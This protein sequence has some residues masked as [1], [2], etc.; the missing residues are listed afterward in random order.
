V[1]VGR[2]SAAQSAHIG[3]PSEQVLV[4]DCCHWSHLAEIKWH[5]TCNAP[6]LSGGALRHCESRLK[7]SFASLKPIGNSKQLTSEWKGADPQI[8]VWAQHDVSQT[9]YLWWKTMISSSC[10]DHVRTS[11]TQGPEDQISMNI[12]ALEEEPGA[13]L[14]S[15]AADRGLL[16]PVVEIFPVESVKRLGTGWG[17]W[18]S[19]SVH[20]STGS[21]I[22]FRFQAPMHLLVMYHEGGR[23]D[24]ETIIDGAAP[25]RA[26]SF[27]NKLTFVPAGRPYREWHETVASTRL[28]FLYL[29]PAKFEKATE[30]DYAPRIYF[31]DSVVWETAAKLKRVIEGA[32]KE[33]T[34]YLE[35]LTNVLAFELSRVDDSGVRDPLVSRGGLASWQ[36]RVVASYIEEHLSEQISLVTLAGLA[37]LSQH[38]FC[39]AFKQSFGLAPHRYHVHRRIE[40]AKV[41]LAE[42]AASVTDVGLTLGYAQ[43]SSF[44]V[45]FRKLTGWTP[46]EYRRQFK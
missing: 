35:A 39:R 44:S 21:R 36:K 22:E 33:R 13:A 42:A 29:E 9:K 23:R 2:T 12:A 7:R 45:A 17:G 3:A 24:G 5:H 14:R 34:P 38:H 18:F 30:T 6:G 31:D 19:E 37:R 41:L 43:T 27:T 20:A 26:R 16:N 32:P 1:L 25:S 15:N 8:I 28:F 10:V 40:R 4:L 46:S 11:M